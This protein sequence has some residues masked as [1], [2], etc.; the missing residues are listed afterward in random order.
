MNSNKKRVK[1][2]IKKPT[3][4]ELVEIWGKKCLIE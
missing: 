1:K 4:D 2:P 3:Y